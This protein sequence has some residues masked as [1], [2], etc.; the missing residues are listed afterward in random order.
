MTKSFENVGNMPK[1]CICMPISYIIMEQIFDI[2][3]HMNNLHLNH[4]Y[5]LMLLLKVLIL[6]KDYTVSLVSFERRQ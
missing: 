1:S 3:I 2:G 4:Y 6:F 5:D